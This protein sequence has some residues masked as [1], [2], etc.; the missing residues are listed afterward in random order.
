MTRYRSA[1]SHRYA[2]ARRG[3]DRTFTRRLRCRA[4]AR[5]TRERAYVV[6]ARR[7]VSS[8]Y[9]LAA[10]RAQRLRPD[11]QRVPCRNRWRMALRPWRRLQCGCR[12]E[13]L[14]AA[15]QRRGGE[16]GGVRSHAVRRAYARLSGSGAHLRR[17]LTVSGVDGELCVRT[18]KCGIGAIPVPP[19]GQRL[20][21]F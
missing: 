6:P 17:C 21:P 4:E 18:R 3:H 19:N 8:R 11:T 13:Y 2:A 15:S 9:E 14:I 7:P 16:P 5:A 12:L 1:A 10:G 20:L